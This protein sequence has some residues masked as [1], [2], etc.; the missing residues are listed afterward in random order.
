MSSMVA[1]HRDA[2]IDRAHDAE[3]VREVFA[4]ASER[5]RRLV[6]FDASVWLAADP[7][8]SLPTAPT[9]SENMGFVGGSDGCLRLWELEFF[10]EDV[11]LYRD[12]ARTATPARGLL[13]STGDRPARSTR[14]REFLEPNGLDDELRAVMRVDGDAWAWLSL[15]REEGRAPFDQ[16]DIDLVAGLSSALGEAVRGHARAE[17]DQVLETEDRGP[18]LMLFAPTGELISMN[19]DAPAW[20]DELPPDSGKTGPRSMPWRSPFDIRFPLVVAAAL[21]RARA[22]AEERDHGSARARMRSRASGRWLVCHASCLRGPDGALGN[23]ALAIEPAKAAEIAPIIVQAYELTPREQEITR[24]IAHGLNTAAIASRLHLSAHTVRDYVKTI[25]DKAGVSSR[26]E[27]VARLFAEHYA[28]THTDP[29]T[30][31][32]VGE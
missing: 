14:Y 24:L 10:F 22:V 27:L 18:G 9:R 31:D 3:S 13:E 19:D 30:Q 5:L 28:P 6:Q 17:P 32:R 23:T 12:L 29:S 4:A 11:N 25:F 26:G 15:Y 21:M 20:L 7:A 2:L 8:T 1:H 16:R